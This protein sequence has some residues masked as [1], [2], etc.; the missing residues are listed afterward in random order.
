[1]V[2][3]C[4]EGTN[5]VRMMGGRVF[6]S[7]RGYGAGIVFFLCLMLLTLMMS[8]MGIDFAHYFTHQNQLQTSAE[9][10][11]LSGAAELFENLSP[12]YSDRLD[13]AYSA[14]EDYVTGNYDTSVNEEDVRYGFYDFAG[15]EGFSETPSGTEYTFTGGYNAM[16]VAAWAEAGR[17]SELPAIM[18]RLFGETQMETAAAATAALDDRVV[19]VSGLR[20]IYS[21][22]EQWNVAASDGDLRN[23]TV[24]IYGD[25]FLLN[26]TDVD[27]PMPAS[28]NWGFADLRDCDSGV[29][30]QSDTQEWFRHG[31]RGYVKANECYST[32]TGNFISS[33]SD[34]LDKLIADRTVIT[35][36]LADDF[37][38][39]SGSAEQVNVSGFTGPCRWAAPCRCGFRD[40]APSCCASAWRWPPGCAR[41]PPS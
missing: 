35:I 25:R 21:C 31:F 28:G 33:I 22:Q 38:H 26:G 8:A 23:D 37:G 24:R 11:A 41:W 29:P 18:A 40:G 36:P 1:M 16:Q 7:A 30:G 10:G 14:A 2:K 4:C 6:A 27:C 34:T 39:G 17:G 5:E 19:E 20:P 12:D 9:A 13:D 3:N 32:Q 15:G